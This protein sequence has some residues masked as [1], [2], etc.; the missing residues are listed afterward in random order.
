MVKMLKFLMALIMILL[1]MMFCAMEKN[2]AWIMK[3][4]KNE[5]QNLLTMLEIVYRLEKI[6]VEI[7]I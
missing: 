1:E 2:L 5:I 7:K 6:L 4:Y 3:D